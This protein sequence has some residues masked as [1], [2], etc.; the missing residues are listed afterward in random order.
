M[1]KLS[2][3]VTIYIP[4]SK[5]AYMGPIWTFLCGAAQMHFCIEFGLATSVD[6]CYKGIHTKNY[7]RGNYIQAEEEL[8]KVNWNIMNEI[9]VIESWNYFYSNVR[10]V[11][12]SCIPETQEKSKASVDGHVLYCSLKINLGHGKNIHT[13]VRE[14]I[15]KNIEKIRNKIPK[16]VR[17]ARRKYEKGITRD[18]NSNPKAFW[19]YVH[20]KSHVK[21]GI[22]DLKDYC[23]N[24]VTDNR[25]KADILNNFF[26]SVFTKETGELP[27]FDVQVDNDI[28]DVIFNV[29]KVREL[30]K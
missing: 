20:S 5:H 2:Q 11:I 15:M 6:A 19:K 14:K 12:D 27:P 18:V 24:N 8:A 29:Q 13:C 9:N 26:S 23:G 22:G 25:S 4:P 1:D 3:L 28:C 21:S 17:H 16:C 30:L 7:Y 10:Q